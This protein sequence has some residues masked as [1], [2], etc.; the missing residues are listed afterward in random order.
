MSKKK[1]KVFGAALD[2]TD[3]EK[4]IAI[5]LNY[6]NNVVHK[7]ETKHNNYQD[8]YNAFIEESRILKD[9]K[10]HEVGRFPVETWLRSK[11]G[12]EDRIFMNPLE[13]RTFLDTNGCKE[14]SETMKNFIMKNILPDI[15]L[16]IGADHSLTGGVLSALSAKYGAENITVVIYDGHFD[17]IPTD[18][19]LSLAKY[20][21]EH[22]DEIQAILP[23]FLDSLSKNTEVPSTYN[24]G[25]FLYYLIEEKIVLPENLIFY[26]VMDYPDETLQDINDPRVK[27]YV[28]FYKKFEE[29][30]VR[31]IPN[32]KDYD[33][34]N[35]SFEE[36]M[37]SIETPYLYLSIDVDVGSLNA[38]LAA[39]FMDFIGVDEKCLIESSEIIKNFLKSG[40]IEIIGMDIMEIEIFFINAQLKS[41]KT[42]KT[43]DIME[44]F[45]ELLL[46]D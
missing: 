11:P 46:I 9:S 40:D 38:V 39:R 33:N 15:P 25:T 4:K 8:S 31:F 20:S 10:F 2:P 1:I 24:C 35:R 14:Y 26:G 23:E 28:N 19:R 36:I 32:D 22:K 12:P 3:S 37:N 16:M 41:G 18:L 5:K 21:K 17:A 27:N 30:G 45:L 43:I 13:F 42:D 34:M 29:K 6:L 7:R 44:K